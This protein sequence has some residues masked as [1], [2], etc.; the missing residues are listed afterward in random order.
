[1]TTQH[2][3]TNDLTGT[4]ATRRPELAIAVSGLASALVGFLAMW[5][6]R[7]S[8]FR[9]SALL[10]ISDS[11]PLAGYVRTIDPGFAFVTANEHYDGVYFY[12]MALD[13]FVQG[14]AHDLITMPA[15]RYGHPLYG[16]L[17]G[18]LSFGHATWL[19]SIFMV[20][21]LASMFFAGLLVATLVFRHGGS[22]W[23]GLAVAASPGLLYSASGVLTEPLQVALTCGALLLWRNRRS[24]P[25]VLGVVLISLCLTKEQLVL[26]PAA[27]GLDLMIR[28]VRERR[29]D[30]GRATA[31]A[32]GPLVLGVWL[33][34]M[35]GQFTPEQL[36]YDDGN[37]GMPVVG[38]LETFKLA[39]SLRRSADPYASQIGTTATSGL[40]ATAVVLVIASVVALRRRD[41][42]GYTVVLMS[43]LVSCLQWRTMPYPHEMFRIP[44]VALLLAVAL[45]GS[46]LGRRDATH[47]VAES[48]NEDGLVL[49]GS[50]AVQPV[51]V[52]GELEDPAGRASAV[53]DQPGGH[54]AT[55]ALGVERHDAGS[56]LGVAVLETR[57]DDA[58]AEA[59]GVDD[60][61]VF[62]GGQVDDD[63]GAR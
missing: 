25:V 62:G 24:N 18:A 6:S 38:W 7:G 20:L 45:V 31:V 15:Y 54:E 48:T 29:L 51:P 23:W 39:V 44:S 27:L 13:P 55:G 42:F 9:A 37:I 16:W 32:V 22:P 14:M 8:D 36:H 17:A 35:R 11:E 61:E 49:G 46:H 58:G 63:G 59:L 34:W 53:A 3:A 50:S 26:V 41:A 12:T 60:A 56:A 28:T 5:S 19:P 21:T 47:T 40:L 2:A 52:G 33:W 1:M 57:A 4:A 30:W 10:G 43:L